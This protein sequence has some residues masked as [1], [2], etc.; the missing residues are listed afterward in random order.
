MIG[1]GFAGI[2]AVLIN[3]ASCSNIITKSFDPSSYGGATSMITCVLPGT[4]PHTHACC[5]L[6]G[7]RGGRRIEVTPNTWIMMI[8]SVYSWEWS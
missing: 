3:S 8:D 7:R 2:Q 6:H 1:N 5:V 4:Y